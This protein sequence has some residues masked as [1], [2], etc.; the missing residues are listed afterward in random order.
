MND[1]RDTLADLVLAEHGGDEPLELLAIEPMLAAPRTAELRALRD[2]ASLATLA[3][4]ADTPPLPV[5]LAQRLEADA[6]AHCLSTGLRLRDLAA[7]PRRQPQPALLRVFAMTALLAAAGLLLLL[8]FQR[9]EPLPPPAA[10]QQLL[11]S[12]TAVQL[13]WQPGPS[14][15]AGSV[16]GDVVWSDRRQ[17]GYL[18]LQGLPPPGAEQQFQLWIVDADR[19]GPPVDGGIFDLPDAAAES[20]VPVR[21]ALPVHARAFVVTV[22][23][24]GGVVVSERRDVVAIAGQ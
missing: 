8:T 7:A 19:P 24:R 9:R 22:E 3:L 12:G 11:A 23:A 10:R 15:L 4:L 6:L 14:P 20:I 2:A 13:E 17:E 5:R 18:R 21:A 16:H 1:P